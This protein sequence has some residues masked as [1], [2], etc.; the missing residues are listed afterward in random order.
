MIKGGVGISSSLYHLNEAIEHDNPDEKYSKGNEWGGDKEENPGW[1][2]S[3]KKRNYKRARKVRKV[4]K[5][6][7]RSRVR[8]RMSRR[9]K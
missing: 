7:S 3:S 8:R 1:G 9:N 5:T 6:R 4:R 2:G